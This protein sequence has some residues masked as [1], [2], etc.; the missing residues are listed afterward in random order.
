MVA[1]V[2]TVAP[3]YEPCPFTRTGRLPLV[4]SLAAS[5]FWGAAVIVFGFLSEV[6]LVRLPSAWDGVIHKMRAKL[7]ATLIALLFL[8][9]IT[10]PP[11]EPN[12]RNG[13]S[14]LS[15]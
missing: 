4:T 10:L 12:E 2:K 6:A 14:L 8:K 11:L 15:A 9:V 13:S 3:V 7:T 1:P 5:L